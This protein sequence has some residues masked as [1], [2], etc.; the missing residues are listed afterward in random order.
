MLA[1]VAQILLAK[2][3]IVG[4][5]IYTIPFLILTRWTVRH[6]GD[7]TDPS[8]L[9]RV[10]DREDLVNLVYY[11][12]LS[13]SSLVFL[14]EQLEWLVNGYRYEHGEEFPSPLSMCLC[15]LQI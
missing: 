9:R 4:T 2:G 6:C 8:Y 11:G 7:P 15:G 10:R 12:A 5:L 13:V 14:P 1:L 3:A